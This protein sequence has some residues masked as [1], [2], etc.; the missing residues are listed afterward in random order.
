VAAP[1]FNR[2]F[3]L[4]PFFALAAV[5]V[6]AQTLVNGE[7]AGTVLDPSAAH[8]P[9]AHLELTQR[10]TGA[11][12]TETTDGSGDFVFHGLI[13]GA[14]D[15]SVTA[16]GFDHS[17]VRGIIVQVGQTT[18]Q[19]V[20]LAIGTN[21]QGVVVSGDQA[22]LLQE[23]QSQIGQV[24]DRKQVDT[25]P[26]KNRDF[27]DLATLVPQVVRSPTV[28]PTKQRVG[29]ISVAG[30]GGRTSNIFVDGFEDF[31]FVIGG[32]AYDV[33]P[34]A[35]QEFNVVT[36]RFSAEQA[37]S[38]SAVI[39]IVQRSGTNKPHG[40]AFYF[41]RNQDLAAK[42]YFETDKS[43]FKR[44][45]SGGTF[46]GPIIK[47]RLFGFAA[48]EDHH[49]SDVGI[50]NTN[51]IYPQYEGSFP[52]P[53]RRDFV[54]AKL[55]YVGGKHRLS[56]RY[57]L[58]D[59]SSAENVGGINSY[60]SGRKDLTTTQSAAGSDTYLISANS[61][62]T[63]GFQYF[64]FKNFLDPLFPL[65]PNF[66][67]P[68]LVTGTQM[69]NP[70]G[71]AETRYEGK[72]DYTL[73]KG[74]HTLRVG[75]EYHWVIGSAFVNEANQGSFNFFTDA[76]LNAQFADLLI[77]S[78][79]NV[80]N[81]SLGTLSSAVVGLY[82]QDDWKIRPNLTLNL[83]IRWDYFSNQND[84][85]FTGILG[86]LAP[87]G[88]RKSDKK[89]FS[90]RVGFAWDPFNK[91][92]FLV[93]G[94]YGI[95]YANVA[96]LD[97]LGEHGFDGRN[98]GFRVYVNPGG[99]D[100]SNPFPGLS[101]Q[102]IH[103]QFFGAPQDPIIALDNHITT[104]YVQYFSGGF[105]WQLGQSYALSVDGVHGLGL[106]GIE[107]RDINADPQFN[108]STPG[109]PLCQMFG[110]TVCNDFGAT[111]W[112]FNGN[113]LHYNALVISLN[114]VL[115][116]RFQFNTS[117]TYSKSDNYFD[118]SV[119]SAG[120]L[121]TD[122]FNPSA[123]R[124]PTTTD[125]R[126]RFVLSGIYDPSGQLF[127][128]GKNWELSLISSFNTPT[129]FNITT[130]ATQADGITPVRPAGIGRNSGARGSQANLLKLVN[131]FRVSQGID[132]LTRALTPQSLDMRDTDLRISKG[133]Q[134]KDNVQL[135]LQGE[136]YN[137]L[138]SSNFISNAGNAGFGISG[139]IGV[140]TSD[141]VGLPTSTPG[142]LGAGGPRTFQLAA[143]LQF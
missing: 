140:A 53:F 108:L 98:L 86:L 3:F 119:G 35:I 132:P 69:G 68:D 113:T 92:K 51:G 46:G 24:I 37:R 139:V 125:Q 136:V 67:R 142:P 112:A 87:P 60:S 38:M 95:Y 111:T 102:Q 54:T 4:V 15:L 94:G 30:T 75:G 77:M 52:L 124:G 12:R 114:K 97:A 127:F 129:P 14:Y 82:A 115:S 5:G 116:Q 99:I 49:E 33:S 74:A 106:K 26:I 100:I 128:L 71:T 28:D 133:I 55:D 143:R 27:T 103:D 117:Y 122:P 56:A 7:I 120:Q 141:N 126:D 76:P 78:A 16:A 96:M 19:R 91:G 9:G 1:R 11:T 59:F 40:S 34:D 84:K 135:K 138:N 44:Q 47:D 70:Q 29:N 62:N 134:F 64:H 32:L 137:A 105:Q 25:L 90:P 39:N 121:L 50:V 22:P 61:L 8:I 93:R 23:S 131:S 101:P 85:N 20:N 36:T 72:D 57:N 109:S 21:Q 80:P 2:F 42:D 107:S 43:P 73:S 63:F 45:Q 83:G 6:G 81:C 130:G 17:D 13:P 65:S 104:P 123:D 41:F 89:D 118:E 31:D 79:C 58:D 10:T 110:Q 18:T 66:V 48:F 88:S